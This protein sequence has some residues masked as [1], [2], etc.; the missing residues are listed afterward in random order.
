MG[1]SEE[2]VTND[3]EGYEE[4]DNTQPEESEDKQTGEE[5]PDRIKGFEDFE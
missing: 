1:E 4:K 5:M 2:D 3:E